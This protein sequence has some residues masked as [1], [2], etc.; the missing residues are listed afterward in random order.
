MLP[1]SKVVL[2]AVYYITFLV[3]CAV[4]IY[5][6]VNSAQKYLDEPVTTEIK[7][8]LGENETNPYYVN[9]PQI[10]ICKAINITFSQNCSL[11]YYNGF[12]Y[13]IEKLFA[14]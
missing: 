14:L 6:T 11:R 12:I 10:T 5:W 1:L 8:V 3:I 4:F 13:E 9:F 7:Y 2:R